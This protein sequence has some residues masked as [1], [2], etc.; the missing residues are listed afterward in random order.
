MTSVWGELK[1]RNVVKVAVA[2]AIVAFVTLQLIDVLQ[3]ILELPGWVGKLILLLLVI[4]L[5]VALVF[6]WVFEL[7]PQG[8]VREKEVDRS[9]SITQVTGRKIDFIIIGVL[10]VGFALLLFDKF[11]LSAVDNEA[12]VEETMPKPT[13]GF[14]VEA[15]P[16]TVAVLAFV[17]MSPSRDQ[18]WLGDSI[19]TE[20]QTELSKRSDLRVL[21]RSSSFSLPDDVQS[22]QAI[23]EYLGVDIL[24]EGTVRRSGD[25]IRVTAQLVSVTDGY[26][27]W[28]DV[29]ESRLGKDFKAEVT[30]AEFFSMRVRDELTG[31]FTPT[32]EITKFAEATDSAFTELFTETGNVN[33][34]SRTNADSVEVMTDD[35]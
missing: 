13:P 19:A 5:P 25:R 33:T 15:S 11:V 29:Y 34:T 20:M 31:P 17:D 27:L 35:Q 28:S 14:V 4:G 26:Q 8:L 30:I 3:D 10:A 9:Q 23:G 22:A 7:T 1:R 24:V 12:S 16:K 21:S 18:R 2:Y 32:V 6:A